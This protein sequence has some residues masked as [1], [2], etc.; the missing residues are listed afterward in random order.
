MRISCKPALVWRGDPLKRMPKLT[1]KGKRREIR[2]KRTVA[3]GSCAAQEIRMLQVKGPSI[4]KHSLLV[5][6]TES[7]L[8]IWICFISVHLEWQVERQTDS[9]D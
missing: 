3:V 9:T 4:A 7:P 5:S 2:L 1:L 8:F 6:G